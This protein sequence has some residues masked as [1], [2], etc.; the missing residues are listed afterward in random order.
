MI[1]YLFR[2][3]VYK[4]Y[5]WNQVFLCCWVSILITKIIYK[6]TQ[7]E[8]ENNFLKILKYN[9]MVRPILNIGTR[10]EAGDGGE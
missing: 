5:K 6:Q 7:K 10:Q 4:C 1:G 3:M 8:V 2:S 9:R